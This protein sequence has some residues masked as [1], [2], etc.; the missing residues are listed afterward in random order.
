VVKGSSALCAAQIV[1]PVRA[2]IGRS[3]YPNEPKTLPFYPNEPKTLLEIWWSKVVR[4]RSF[5]TGPRQDVI[6]LQRAPAIRTRKHP[7]K[8]DQTPIIPA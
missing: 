4:K 2:G 6:G 1:G 3:F 7:I 5:F 8:T